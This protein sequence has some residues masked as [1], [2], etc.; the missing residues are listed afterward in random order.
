MGKAALIFW[1]GCDVKAS[2]KKVP[3]FIAAQDDLR[4][5]E[6]QPCQA[7]LPVQ[8]GIPGRLGDDVVKREQQMAGAVAY[9]YI[10]KVQAGPQAG[11]V[12]LD[13]ANMHRLIYYTAEDLFDIAVIV[14]NL[15]QYA[16]AQDEDEKSRQEIQRDA[17]PNAAFQTGPQKTR[18]AVQRAYIG[19][20]LY[21]AR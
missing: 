17:S 15:R 20:Q 2:S 19:L 6:F 7:Q 9:L 18:P 13:A 21:P 4:G 11:P 8:K 10:F 12:G 14:F 3:R 16:V 5:D 1:F